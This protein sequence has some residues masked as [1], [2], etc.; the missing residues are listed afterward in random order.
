MAVVAASLS[1]SDG[2]RDGC[3]MNMLQMMK[4]FPQ[5]NWIWQFVLYQDFYIIKVLPHTAGFV[6]EHEGEVR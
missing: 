3:I 5:Q 4:E 6:A 2:W 1:I